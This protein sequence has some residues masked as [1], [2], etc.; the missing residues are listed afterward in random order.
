MYL[1]HYNFIIKVE[2]EKLWR[3]ERDKGND[4]IILET[5][6]IIFRSTHPLL[7]K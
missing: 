6:K 4:E 1:V 7:K 5:Q 2:Y 3:E